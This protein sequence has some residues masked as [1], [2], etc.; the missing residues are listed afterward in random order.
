MPPPPPPPFL[1][2]S[3]LFPLPLASPP[4]P[5]PAPR[6]PS[7]GENT[8]TGLSYAPPPPSPVSSIFRPLP[9]AA[10]QPRRYR[11]RLR[12]HLPQGRPDRDRRRL[13]EGNRRAGPLQLRRLRAAYGPD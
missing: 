1:L 13:P 11:P 6:P 9:P 8:Y 5:A 3:V 2:S 7:A 10:G 12:R 4:A